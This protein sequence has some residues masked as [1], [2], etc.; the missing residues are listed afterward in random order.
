MNTF[1]VN[2]KILHAPPDW[3]RVSDDYIFGRHVKVLEKIGMDKQGYD[4]YSFK[5]SGACNLYL[6][7]VDLLQIQRQCRHKSVEQTMR[8]LRDL[9]MFRK[10]DHFDKVK[11][12]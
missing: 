4:L 3:P 12:F 9:E 11:S 7:G 2:V 5:H 8:Y 10:K 1:L 6:S